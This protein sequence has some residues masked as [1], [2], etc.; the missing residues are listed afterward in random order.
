MAQQLSVMVI[1]GEPIEEAEHS[2]AFCSLRYGS[3]SCIELIIQSVGIHSNYSYLHV[4]T[5]QLLY[6][7]LDM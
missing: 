3:W 1:Q 6:H 2:S 5:T 7:M 4:E